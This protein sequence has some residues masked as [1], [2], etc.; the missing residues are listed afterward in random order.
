MAKDFM[1]DDLPIMGDIKEDSEKQNAAQEKKTE[2]VKD[3]KQEEKDVLIDTG[4]DTEVIKDKEVKKTE[5]D[6]WNISSFNSEFKKEFKTSE[7]IQ[8]LFNATAE[9]KTL[10][11][12]AADNKKLLEEKENL[13]NTKTDGLKLFADDNM[14]KINQVLIKNPNL[15]KAALLRLASADLDKMQDTEVLKLQKLTKVRGE[16]FSEADIDH[17]IKRQYNLTANPSELEGEELK[18]YNADKFN[19]SE[20]AQAARLELKELMNVEMP[21]K[22]DLL[23]MQNES[24]AKADKDYKD[25]LDLWKPK[26]DEFIKKL[27]KITV[28]F[29]K[30]D[31]FEFSYDDEFKTYLGKNLAAF[32]ALKGLDANKPESLEAIKKSVEDDFYLKKRDQMFKTFK[33]DLLSKVKDAEYKDKHNIPPLNEQEAPNK[34]TD[35]EKRNKAANDSLNERLSNNKYF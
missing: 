9:L 2:E 3:T 4:K 35:T 12:S 28:E 5:D 6:K 16:G 25:S 22:I 21:E 7:E 20:A 24:K 11:E 19:M 17:A 26:T 10:R 33:A 13:L 23:A 30:D 31:K 32:A 18:D 1:D 29:E 14:Y 27:D 15:N 8:A 34:L